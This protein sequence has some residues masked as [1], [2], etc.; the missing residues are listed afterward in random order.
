VYVKPVTYH[1]AHG[2]SPQ[3]S[4]FK[5]ACSG[6]FC[7][8]GTS[9]PNRA[10][11]GPAATLSR[12]P[13]ASKHVPALSRA[14]LAVPHLIRPDPHDPQGSGDAERESTGD[15]VGQGVVQPLATL[16]DCGLGHTEWDR[17]NEPTGALRSSP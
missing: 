14:P 4:N 16:A 5:N 9:H 10:H 1:R 13:M 3:E 15:G 17:S 6:T 12:S 7:G 11:R 8:R 2:H